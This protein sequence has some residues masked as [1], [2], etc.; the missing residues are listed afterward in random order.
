MNKREF[1]KIG[2]IRIPEPIVSYVEGH[3]DR[4]QIEQSAFD[5]MNGYVL[6]TVTKV[7]IERYCSCCIFCGWHSAKNPNQKKIPGEYR[8]KIKRGYE[9]I[10]HWDNYSYNSGSLNEAFKKAICSKELPNYTPSVDDA[11][12]EYY[13]RNDAEPKIS[14]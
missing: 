6:D 13:Q 10:F 7:T 9:P 12:C 14:A 11:I 3:G 1:D 2:L 5:A 4:I 8:H